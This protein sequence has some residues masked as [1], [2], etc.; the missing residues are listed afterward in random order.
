MLIAVAVAALGAVGIVGTVALIRSSRI[1]STSPTLVPAPPTTAQSATS[2]PSPTP[3]TLA[4]PPELESGDLIVVSLAEGEEIRYQAPV[5]GESYVR[6]AIE[7][8]GDSSDPFL[9]LYDAEGQLLAARDDCGGTLNSALWLYNDEPATYEISTRFIDGEA[10]EYGLAFNTF[11]PVSLDLRFVGTF[12]FDA[13]APTN[14][15]AVMRSETL[16]PWLELS[17][18]EGRFVAD[19]NCGA[20][21]N[22]S[23]DSELLVTEVSGERSVLVGFRGAP[24]ERESSEYVLSVV[25]GEADGF[26]WD[27]I[28]TVGQR[29]AILMSSVNGDSMLELLGPDGA[30]IALDEDSGDG[31]DAE[32]V[33]ILRARGTYRVVG[34]FADDGEADM[35]VAVALRSA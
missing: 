20:N 1:D 12:V 7:A 3:S 27:F 28:G 16:D 35:N 8:V 11:Q 26:E 29:F 13:P 18:D 10:G 34:R 33:S 15:R 22:N 14:V 19:D 4:G 2:R 5:A 6:F 25:V 17:L 30:S 23:L 24:Q 9:A 21:N 31:G 32:I